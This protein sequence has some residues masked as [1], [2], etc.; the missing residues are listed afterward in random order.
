[1][2][3]T[4]ANIVWVVILDECVFIDFFLFADFMYFV[5]E[6]S[7]YLYHGSH[8][9]IDSHTY[10]MHILVP[11]APMHRIEIRDQASS[12]ISR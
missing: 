9:F 1:M 5:C 2:V 11:I 8:P 7:T 3:S 4:E 10:T 12:G 6:I